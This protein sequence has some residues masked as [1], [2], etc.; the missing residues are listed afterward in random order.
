MKLVNPFT[1]RMAARGRLADSVLVL[2]Y[3]GRRS[4]RSFDVPAGYHDVDGIISVFTSSPWRHNFAGGRDIEVTLHGTRRQARALLVDDPGAVTD[5]LDR[6][7]SELGYRQAG[8]RLGLRFNV[9]RSPT[10][11]ELREAVERSGL[12]TV[13]ILDRGSGRG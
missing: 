8:R 5:V 12:C 9:G 1:R 6:L 11:A 3:I 2:H 13:Q 4:A 7:I 10:R